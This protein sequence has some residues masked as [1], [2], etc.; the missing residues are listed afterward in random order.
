MTLSPQIRQAVRQRANFLCEFCGVA[1]SDHAG[2]LTI[3]HFQP[4]SKGGTDELN[5]LIYCCMRCNQ[6]KLD[7]WPKTPDQLM[8]WNP[9]SQT[10]E[11]HFQYL[12][13]GHLYPLT[14]TAAFTIE[15]LR[16]NRPSLI[17]YR[18]AKQEQQEHQELLF[19][20]QAIVELLRETSL[21]QTQ[22]LREQQ[23]LLQE[24]SHLIAALLKSY[25]NQSDRQNQAEP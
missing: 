23:T 7:Y 11:S 18:L 22:L 24:Q 10:Q 2:L 21:R 13:N 25:K 3:D 1:E 19:H 8:I 15:R 4:R 12:E 16:L 20:Y 6:Y 17:Q 14:P 9:R 5:N